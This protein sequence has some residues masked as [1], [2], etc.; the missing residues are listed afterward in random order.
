MSER[1]RSS[2]DD[3]PSSHRN[4]EPHQH[5]RAN[6]HHSRSKIA[7]QSSTGP[8]SIRTRAPSATPDRAR[9]KSVHSRS[10]RKGSRPQPD[11]GDAASLTSAPHTPDPNRHASSGRSRPRSVSTKR[12]PPVPPEDLDDDLSTQV[13]I[14]A[15]DQAEQLM[16]EVPN[17]PGRAEGAATPNGSDAAL[18]D[19]NGD[20]GEWGSDW[21]GWELTPRHDDPDDTNSYVTRS[22]L[23]GLFD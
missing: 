4:N 15:A 8:S 14:Q 6:S 5:E 23:Q 19:S 17:L 3:V 18:D 9:S 1:S 2:R 22:E 21:T 12:K 11:G 7:S 16:Q 20:F 13:L 10:S